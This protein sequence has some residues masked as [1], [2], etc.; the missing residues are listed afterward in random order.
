M[1]KYIKK[2]DLEKALRSSYMSRI[3]VTF[4]FNKQ[5]HTE[6]FEAPTS[7]IEKAGVWS[8]EI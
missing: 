3:K 2:K 7:D 8:F 6:Y 1:S 4:S 5:Y